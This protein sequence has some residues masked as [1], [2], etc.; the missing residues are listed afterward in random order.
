MSL[1]KKTKNKLILPSFLISFF[2]LIILGGWLS[3]ANLNFNFQW[4]SK[5]KMVNPLPSPTL[6]E[7]LE[8]L[9]KNQGLMPVS[10]EFQEKEARVL[11]T[12]D[13]TALFSLEK[14]LPSQTLALQ[15]ILSRSKIEGRL[16]KVVDLRFSKPVI[17]Y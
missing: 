11:L 8:S 10:L 7:N 1:K 5:Q 16:P 4:P 17:S 9:L 12:G 3:K 14:D 2:I 15:F 13:L 6:K